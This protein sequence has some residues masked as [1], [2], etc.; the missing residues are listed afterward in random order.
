MARI[1]RSDLEDM[2]SRTADKPGECKGWGFDY[3]KVTKECVFHNETG[4]TSTVIIDDTV[5]NLVDLLHRMA[6]REKE[7]RRTREA[8]SRG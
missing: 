8:V 3:N 1:D 6:I 5:D 2:C 4:E 7:L